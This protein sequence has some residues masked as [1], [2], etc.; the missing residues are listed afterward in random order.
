MFSRYVSDGYFYSNLESLC[1][2]K[3]QKE[4]I[5]KY[6][7]LESYVVSKC[8]PASAYRLAL[9]VNNKNISIT[10]LQNIIIKS[11]SSLY[12]FRFARDIKKANVKRLQNCIVK[13]K[14]INNITKF[15][16]F[17]RG[18]NKSQIQD[19]ILAHKSAKCSY[20][21]IKYVPLCDANVFK[22]LILSSKRP[23]YLF[24]LAQ[25]IKSKK[26]LNIIQDLILESKSYT[27]VRLFAKNINGADIIRL[28][29]KI[30]QSGNIDEIKKFSKAIPTDRNKRIAVL[31]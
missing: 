11:R 23:R 19:L 20:M 2:T 4:Y 17:V 14:D 16:C 28:E 22:N 26:D 24:E 1:K 12:L 31:F 27:Y 9:E 8:N 18:A 7:Q 13:T 10:K 15:A 25:H 30:L 6:K 21:Y 29:D 3:E 5:I